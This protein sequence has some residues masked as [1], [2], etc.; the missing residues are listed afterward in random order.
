M[1]D[2]P[3]SGLAPRSSP[4]RREQNVILATLLL[5]ALAAWGILVWQARGAM[6]TG[7]TMGMQ[8]SVFLLVWVVMMVAMMFPAAA[9][10]MLVFARFQGEKRRKG[11]A[12]VPT[13]VFVTAYLVIWLGA[14]AVGYLGALVG[15]R[16]GAGTMW[17]MADG[18]RLT[19]AL[20]I[21]AGV[22]QVTPLKRVC[23]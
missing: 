22:Y 20:L 19:G 4:L 9:P 5:L 18:A 15:E 17:L 11:R 7:L 12:F 16:I 13:W 23:L 21:L 14:G 2:T 1:I 10:V 8:A 3:S 6:Q